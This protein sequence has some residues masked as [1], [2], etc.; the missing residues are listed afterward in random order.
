MLRSRKV[1]MSHQEFQ[2]QRQSNPV[3]KK[4]TKARAGGVGSVQNSKT[5]PKGKANSIV[6][7]RTSGGGGNAM[8]GSESMSMSN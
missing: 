1:P 8:A 2:P 3:A 6:Q 4:T 7:N 5:A